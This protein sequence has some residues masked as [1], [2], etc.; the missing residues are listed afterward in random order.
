MAEKLSNSI[1]LEIVTPERQ[2]FCGE[3]DA[4]TVPGING[5]MGIL[6]GHAPL[7]SELK[8]GVI[9]ARKGKDEERFFCSWGFVEVLSDQVS[10]LAEQVEAASEIDRDEASSDKEKADGLLKSKDPDS[11]FVAAL[12]LWEKS[13]ARLEVSAAEKQ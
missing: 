8:I 9:T 7:L 1:Q 6:P 10:V 5:Y 2:F 13:V 11:D 12:E 4:V 3:V